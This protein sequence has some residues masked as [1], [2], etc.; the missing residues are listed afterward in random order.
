MYESKTKIIPAKKLEELRA[1]SREIEVDVV[2]EDDEHDAGAPSAADFDDG[3]ATE[4][5]DLESMELAPSEAPEALDNYEELHD[6]LSEPPQE[7]EPDPDEPEPEESF[8]SFSRPTPPPAAKT[9]SPSPD[10]G[11]PPP[12]A[13]HPSYADM[14]APSP[15]FSSLGPVAAIPPTAPLAIPR[16]SPPRPSTA[17]PPPPP[18]VPSKK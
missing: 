2:F 17:T 5:A 12:R 16:P 1:E 15:S 14:R 4:P 3:N 7:L 10:S 13:S 18:S 9:S 11:P 8:A 6:A